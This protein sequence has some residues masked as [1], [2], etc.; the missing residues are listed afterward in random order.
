MFLIL[1]IIWKTQNSVFIENYCVRGY[2]FHKT[3]TDNET[4]TRKTSFWI[5]ASSKY[6]LHFRKRSYLLSTIFNFSAYMVNLFAISL[7]VILMINILQ[8]IIKVRSEKILKAINLSR[9]N[10]DLSAK[11]NSLNGYSSKTRISE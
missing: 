7:F 6:F 8:K 4:A 9:F 10:N 5:P 2:N 1:G 3:V 11:N